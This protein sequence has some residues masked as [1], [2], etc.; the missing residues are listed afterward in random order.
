MRTSTTL[1]LLLLTAAAAAWVFLHER[2]GPPPNLGGHLLFDYSERVASAGAATI[3]FDPGTAAAIDLKS[4]SGQFSL[5]RRPDGSWDITKP[6]R[7]RA[8]PAFIRQLLDFCREARIADTIDRSELRRGSVTAASI[9][10]DDKNAWRVTWRDP[11]GTK[12]ADV[13][14]GRTAPL[15]NAAYVSIE[16]QRRRPDI[17]VTS[18]DLR[19][20]LAQPV[21]RFRD[22]RVTRFNAEEVTSMAVRR[23][24]GEVQFS[25][26]QAPRKVTVRGQDGKPKEELD[27]GS[28][29]LIS[30][31]LL[32][33]PASQAAV[34]DFVAMMC[35]ARVAGWIP[36]DKAGSAEEKPL[37]EVTLTG[38]PGTK[39]DAFAFHADASSPATVICTSRARR[40]SFKVPKEIAD[41]LALA[42]NP[43]NFRD[44]KL[45]SMEARMIHTLQVEMLDGESVLLRRVGDKWS[46]RPLAG[47]TWQPAASERVE[48]LVRTVNDTDITEFTA[49]SLADPKA[50]A[51]D[52]PAFTLTFGIE[53]NALL[54]Q[55]AALTPQNSVALRLG[56]DAAGK[57]HANFA[58]Q[59]FVYRIGPELAYAIPTRGLKWRSLALPGWT[60]RQVRA[61]R[62]AVGSAPPVA[63]RMDPLTFK[64]TA[65]RD[66]V[67]VTPLLLPAAAE[68]LA[69]RAGSLQAGNWLADGPAATAALATP[70]LTLDVT[71]EVFDDDK[72]GV[73][74]TE[75][76]RIELAPMEAGTTAPFCYGRMSGI[77]D[78]FL[79]DTRVLRELSAPL[80]KAAPAGGS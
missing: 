50:F 63:L 32:N 7:D 23:G 57:V 18:P 64:W 62:L 40:C 51:L 43:D 1:V 10:L 17:Y 58:G 11:G 15:G 41:D 55:P 65:E 9:G 27:E 75:D 44:P 34:R 77:A 74:R 12:L 66:G 24:E 80:L 26:Q 71:R 47:G 73:S 22:P 28:P 54:D 39:P 70:A 3:E 72:P 52:R 21:D 13:R 48:A 8:D 16:D 37:L 46:W 42:E 56:I 69:T 45:A 2:R 59:P 6:I 60:L 79:I 76:V 31:P 68:A 4:A 30:R 19:S 53:P 25:R 29:W 78:P 61:L 5:R 67:D 35:G 33:A 49:D 38:P 20:V 36:A 14:V